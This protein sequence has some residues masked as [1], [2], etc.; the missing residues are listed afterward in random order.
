MSRKWSVSI[1]MSRYVL[2]YVNFFST[3]KGFWGLGREVGL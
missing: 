3:S 2:I 1:T